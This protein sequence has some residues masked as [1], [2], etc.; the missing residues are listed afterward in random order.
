MR[1]LGEVIAAAVSAREEPQLAF[2]GV[3]FGKG[4]PGDGVN[5]ASLN[6]LVDYVADGSATKPIVQAFYKED[7]GL[8]FVLVSFVLEYASH[9]N[10]ADQVTEAFWLSEFAVMVNEASGEQVAFLRGDLA[11][12]PMYITPFGQ[13]A[14]DIRQFQTSFVVTKELDVK[15]SFVP[16]N[17]LTAQDMYD[18]DEGVVRP[19]VR[20]ETVGLIKE[21]NEDPDAHEGTQSRI[22]ALEK[23]FNGQG[24]SNFL[25]DFSS[26]VGVNLIKGVWNAADCRMEY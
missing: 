14:L 16:L 24:A 10:G 8:D 25:Y 1:L 2:C 17:W 13:G 4:T 23:A 18:Y 21:H 11:G 9:K 22:A 6:G 19:Q 7:G 12:C 15:I 5:P 3:Q 20:A 26:L